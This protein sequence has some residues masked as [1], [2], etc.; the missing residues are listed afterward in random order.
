MSLGIPPG[1]QT[2]NAKNLAIV[3]QR[4]DKLD[5]LEASV[6]Q[7]MDDPAY[8]TADQQAQLAKAKQ[9]IDNARTALNAEKNVREDLDNQLTPPADKDAAKDDLKALDNLRKKTYPKY[10]KNGA[11]VGDPCIPCLTK[12]VG[13]VKPALMPNSDQEAAND[14]TGIFEGGQPDYCALSDSP[15]DLGKLSYGKHQASETSG[16][17]KDMLQ[18]YSNSTDPAP[19]PALKQ[20]MDK[21]L[22]NFNDD[23][24]SYDGTPAQRADLKKLLKK[25]CKDPAMQKT[26]DDFFREKFWDPAVAKADKYGVKTPLGKAMYYDMEIQGGGLVDGFSKR[27]LK[28]WSDENGVHPPATAC[29]PDDP[30]GPDEK[31][32]LYLVDDERR[33]KMENSANPDYQKTTYRPNSFDTLLDQDNMDLSQDYKLQGQPVKG[34]PQMGDFPVSDGD[35]VN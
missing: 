6:D 11:R 21:Q 34:I 24:D 1:T 30:N 10:Y 5:S 27:A 8:S 29:A 15:T 13:R 28:R 18:R 32:F 25:A 17:L 35:S 3:N 9:D 2:A 19:D 26:Q 14:I 12:E 20:Q 7:K 4:L 31:T 33:K 23:G 16:N 22:D